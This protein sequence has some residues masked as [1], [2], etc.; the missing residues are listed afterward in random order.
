MLLTSSME[1]GNLINAD[2]M[3]QRLKV[4]RRLVTRSSY[5]LLVEALMRSNAGPQTGLKDEIDLH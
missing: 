3:N 5:I 2:Q 1:K 4:S